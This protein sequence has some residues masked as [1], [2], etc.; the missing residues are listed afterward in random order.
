MPLTFTINREDVL[1]T[2]VIEPGWY[3]TKITKVIQQPATTDGST[4]TWIDMVITD[5]PQKDVP[6]RRNF[7]EKAPGFAISFIIALGGNIDPEKGG[8]F[9]MERAVGKAIMAYVS[10]GMYNN[11]PQNNVDDFKAAA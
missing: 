7:N 9:D 3:K 6:L 5:G 1:R 4:N 10:S 11:K 2:R 8:T